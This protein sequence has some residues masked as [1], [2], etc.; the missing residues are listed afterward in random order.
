MKVYILNYKVKFLNTVIKY[1]NKI[2]KIKCAQGLG[3]FLKSTIRVRKRI[4]FVKVKI[5]MLMLQSQCISQT[6]GQRVGDNMYTA[7]TWLCANH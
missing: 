2:W 6:E 1:L 3:D 5:K 7:S 4:T